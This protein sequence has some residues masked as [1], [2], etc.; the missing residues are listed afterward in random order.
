MILVDRAV[1]SFELQSLIQRFGV[2][3]EKTGLDSADAVFEGFGPEGQTLI[4]VERKKIQDALDCVETGR[5]GGFQLPKMRKTYKFCFV[6]IEGV[7]KPDTRHGFLLRQID[8]GDGRPWWSEKGHG[9]RIEKYSKLRRYLFSLTMAGAHVLYT[10]DITHTAYDICELYHW[11][12][13]PWDKHTSMQQMYSGYWW[14]RQTGHSEELMMIPTISGKPS[15]VR[16][17]AACLDGIG[18]KMSADV[19]RVFT[20]PR[21]LANA[22]EDELMKVPGVGLKTA[23]DIVRQILGK[24]KK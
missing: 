5:L 18:V 6:I 20:T 9:G 2:Q 21:A 12:S 1:G 23:G 11:F 13:K 10:R 19:E 14:D 4:G 3:C 15:L 22:D 7:W 24:S 8:K 17:W 16:R